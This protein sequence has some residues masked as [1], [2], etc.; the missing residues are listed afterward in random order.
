MALPQQWSE[1]P[2]APQ[3]QFLVQRTSR[4]RLGHAA[5]TFLAPLTALAVQAPMAGTDG[6]VYPPKPVPE[7]SSRSYRMGPGRGR[8]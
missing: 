7:T 6:L 8:T 1:A 5:M 4:T 2:D 3:V